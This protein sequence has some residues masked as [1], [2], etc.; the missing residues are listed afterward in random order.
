MILEIWHLWLLLTI[1][2]FVVEIFISTF[3]CLCF[4]ASALV[5]GLLA[6][7]G[8]D[9]YIEIITF[10]TLSIIALLLVKPYLKNNMVSRTALEINF[11]T[12]LIGK[13]AYVIERID[14]SKNLGKVIVG[15][16]TWKAKTLYGED[17][18]K[19]TFVKIIKMDQF[20]LT[21]KKDRD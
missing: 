10:L 16:S 11:T 19:D 20:S 18:S 12:N 17:I 1:S 7:W 13:E 2:L 5:T 6:Y 3:T 15:G 8:F 4:G 14:Q 21:V 9:F